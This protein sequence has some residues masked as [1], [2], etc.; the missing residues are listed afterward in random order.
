MAATLN[1]IRTFFG[2]ENASTFAKDWR[3]MSEVDKEHIRK[4]LSDG[5]FTY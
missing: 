4:G 3:Q 5:T 2:Y 1:E